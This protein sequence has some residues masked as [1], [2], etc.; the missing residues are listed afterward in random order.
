MRVCPDQQ[1]VPLHKADRAKPPQGHV[2]LCYTLCRDPDSPRRLF[3]LCQVYQV[4]RAFAV[5]NQGGLGEQRVGCPRCGKLFCQLWLVSICKQRTM[6]TPEQVQCHRAFAASLTTSDAYSASASVTGVLLPRWAWNTV[7]AGCTRSCNM[8]CWSHVVTICRQLEEAFCA[9][10]LPSL[11]LFCTP[12]CSGGLPNLSQFCCS[13]ASSRQCPV[14]LMMYTVGHL[15]LCC[16]Q[17]RRACVMLYRLLK[18]LLKLLQAVWL[19]K[20]CLC[21]IETRVTSK[22]MQE[23][24]CQL[25]CHAATCAC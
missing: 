22:G 1:P 2:A 19:F 6:W 25:S 5:V 3:S 23:A 10:V 24:A 12:D 20:G 13:A 21:L 16:Q 9:V 15:W 14:Q 11:S 17:A 18:L 7:K 4:L 8:L